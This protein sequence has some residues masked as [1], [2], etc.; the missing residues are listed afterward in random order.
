MV[1]DITVAWAMPVDAAYLGASME[2][3]VGSKATVTI[4]RLCVQH[5]R[6][7]SPLGKLPPELLEMIATRIQDAL[8]RKRLRKWQNSIDCCADDCNP[9]AHFSRQQLQRMKLDP[10]FK[11]SDDDDFGDMPRQTGF[12]D[13]EHIDA[14]ET[15]LHKIEDNSYVGSKQTFNKCRKV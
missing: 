1:N 11:D 15:F 4:F 8:F 2:S 3:H 5:A 14:I 6:I 7:G 12:S 9:S 13:K 10:V